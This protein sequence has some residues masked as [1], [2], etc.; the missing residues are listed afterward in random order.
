ME[1]G[2]RPYWMTPNGLVVQSYSTEANVKKHQL[3]LSGRT[4]KFQCNDHEGAPLDKRKSL[5]KLTADYVHSMDAAFLEQFV[6]HWGKAYHK[7][8][9]TV[10]DCMATTLDNVAMM[11]TELQD[12]F[13]RFYSTNHLDVLHH[14]IQQDLNKPLPKPPIRGDLEW[15]QIG[16]NPFLFS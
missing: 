7:P 10:H 12:Q 13:S 16:T 15:R 1:C 14:N 5:S 8:I 2:H 11:R 3:V 6:W 4:V 9:V